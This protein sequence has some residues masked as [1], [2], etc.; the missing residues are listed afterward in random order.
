MLEAGDVVVLTGELGAGKTTFVRG[1]AAGL[2][3]EG[4]VVS[5]TFTLVREYRGRLPILH[6][7]LYRLD[8]AQ[9]VIDLGGQKVQVLRVAENRI[10]EIVILDAP[11]TEDAQ[12]LLLLQRPKH[13]NGAVRKNPRRKEARPA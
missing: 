8:R 1:L 5:P 2:D 6:V 9:E 12:E 4:P 10:R 11:L 13:P 3:A 7:D